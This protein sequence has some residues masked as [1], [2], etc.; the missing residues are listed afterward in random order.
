MQNYF[1]HHQ[2]QHQ[3]QT[4]YYWKTDPEH[5]F[6]QRSYQFP[7][8]PAQIGMPQQQQFQQSFH[9]QYAMQQNMSNLNKYNQIEPP[10]PQPLVDL[11]GVKQEYPYN[12][13]TTLQE[14]HLHQQN[15]IQSPDTILSSQQNLYMDNII[16]RPYDIQPS[17]ESQQ[18]PQDM[19]QLSHAQ[20][21]TATT[22]DPTMYHNRTYQQN[23]VQSHHI[24]PQQEHQH[25]QPQLQQQSHV[26]QIQLAYNANSSSQQTIQNSQFDQ[27][28]N[29]KLTTYPNIHKI[30]STLT[31]S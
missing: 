15:L 28:A 13:A 19:Q 5:Q 7:Q 21:A 9:Q 29:S 6:A 24:Q 30:P 18:S 17:S 8:A 27:L 10:M 23:Q 31:N 16:F 3:N 2:N 22:D 1:P 4:Q 14:N 12:T 20:Q 26:Q 25:Q 11:V